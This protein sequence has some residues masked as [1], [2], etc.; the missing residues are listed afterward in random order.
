MNERGVSIVLWIAVAAILAFILAPILVTIAV[1]FTTAPYLSFPP[2]GF[3][4]EWFGRAIEN[5]E[6]ISGLLL[7]L[8]IGLLAALAGC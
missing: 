1:A 4:W 7:S 3:T 5:Q 6:F 2:V 8:Q